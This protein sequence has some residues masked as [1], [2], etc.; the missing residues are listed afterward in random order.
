VKEDQS[1]HPITW[2]IWL[3]AIL[4]L[5]ITTRNPLYLIIILLCIA[6]LMSALPR[7]MGGVEPIISPWRLAMVIVPLSA[8]FNAATAHFGQTVLFSLPEGILLLGGPITL[9]AVVFGALNG[10]VLSGIF[11]AFSVL[12]Q[13]LSIRSLVRLIPRA[14]HPVA[15]IIII[16]LSF[17]PSMTRQLQQIREAQAI[18][19]HRIRGLRDWLPLF[20]PLL[21]GG[22]ERALQL[23][24]AMTARGFAGHDE[25]IPAATRTIIVVGMSGVLTGW[26]LRLGW[27]YNILGYSLMLLGTAAVG[28]ALWQ[29]GRRLP[30]TTY[31]HE[32]WRK[33]DW[34]ILLTSLIALLP[35][36]PLPF[37]EP[38]SLYYYPYPLLTMPIFEPLLAIMMLALLGP[39]FV[40]GRRNDNESGD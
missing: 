32:P 15:V 4:A 19:G 36:I 31:R 12:N 35:L 17:V 20:M 33:Q 37:I 16:A 34:A 1:L 5:L 27:G 8:I 13:A 3:I 7:T 18:R 9:E 24:E 39:V 23:A 26:L 21:I 2:V 6:I 10:L 11:A 22:L 40:V 29:A 28:I 14:F 38:S 25:A 30:H